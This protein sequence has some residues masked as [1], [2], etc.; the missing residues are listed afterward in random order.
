MNR[1]PQ[2]LVVSRPSAGWLMRA[3]PGWSLVMLL[4]SGAAV[5]LPA[6]GT[7]TAT[8]TLTGV[9]AGGGAYNYT[10]TLENAASST[11]PIGSFWYAWIPGQFYLPTAPSGVQA[12]TGWSGSIVTVGA[13]SI[14]YVASS[15]ASYLAPGSSLTF[16]FT[17]TDTP[18]VLS[19]DA[20]NFPGTPI[21][22]TVVYGAG[23][24]ST[25]SETI[26]IT[27]VPEP[28]ALAL[29]AVGGLGL[30]WIARR[31]ARAEPRA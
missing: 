30:I 16:G 15:S 29:L 7:F 26:V 6:Q 14:Q 8:G 22:T 23:L 19:G 12:P 25:P 13:S 2:V 18:A 3:L 28:S 24:F 20:P 1:K 10:I 11:S 27:S 17:S 21:G 31:R 5:S 4:L 9:P